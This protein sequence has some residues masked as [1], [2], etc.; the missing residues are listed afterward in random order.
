MIL[1]CISLMTGNAKH[2]F[3]CVFVAVVVVV[4]YMLPLEK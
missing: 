4:S 1:I 3:I 2:L